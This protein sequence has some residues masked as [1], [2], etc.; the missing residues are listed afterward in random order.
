VSGKGLVTIETLG[1]SYT[2]TR[3]SRPFSMSVSSKIGEQLAIH[4]N[5]SQPG[6]RRCRR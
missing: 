2:G 6:S 4:F 1:K 5:T 3:P